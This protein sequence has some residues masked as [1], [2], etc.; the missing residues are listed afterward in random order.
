MSNFKNIILGLFSFASFLFCIHFSLY[1]DTIYLDGLANGIQVETIKME[2]DNITVSMF[3]DEIN[4]VTM[5]FDEYRDFPD[6]VTL[7][8]KTKIQCKIYKML[9]EKIIVTFPK[10][11]VRSLEMAFSNEKAPDR[12]KNGYRQQHYDARKTNK[13]VSNRDSLTEE[14]YDVESGNKPS[15]DDTLGLVM[16]DEDETREK[17]TVDKRGDYKAKDGIKSKLLSEI[18]G[19]SSGWG[20][21]KRSGGFDLLDKT[22]QSKGNSDRPEKKTFE[23]KKRDANKGADF[24]EKKIR[25]IN[26][27]MG[28]INGRFL[29]NGEPLESCKVRLVK[30]RKEGETYYKD[31]A[32][33]DS[34]EAITD[35]DGV[36]TFYN[37]PPG[38]HKLY[39]KPLRESSW[40]RRVS[41]EPDVVVKA[42][43]IAYLND[44][45][46]NQKIL[47]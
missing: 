28:V 39:W 31:S 16:L 35:K 11:V 47:N 36:Y 46:T 33:S 3:K 37:V 29:V 30:L 4:S 18:K 9:D 40:I 19:N 7:L 8:S 43:K 20:A 21:S 6:M 1:G 41:M 12:E 38:Y 24:Q 34:F 45:E 2:P 25:N 14:R 42:G 23:R 17:S 5:G 13:N 26:E 32:N 27:N 44:I 22:L 15:N 10:N